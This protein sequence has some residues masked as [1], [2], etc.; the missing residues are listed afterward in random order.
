MSLW[1]TVRRVRVQVRGPLFA[2]DH[3]GATRKGDEPQVRAAFE[4]VV[5]Q[6]LGLDVDRA[7]GAVRLR[8]FAR[9]RAAVLG[10]APPLPPRPE[11]TRDWAL[12]AFA[13]GFEE[14][15]LARAVDAMFRGQAPARFA[16][17]RLARGLVD[18]RLVL[19]GRDVRA[20]RGW[21]EVGVHVVA[22]GEMLGKIADRHA[23]PF[24]ALALS[25]GLDDP[26]L[27]QVGAALELPRPPPARPRRAVEVRAD[28]LVARDRPG[29][30][31]VAT[32]AAGLRFVS[33]AED[34]GWARLDLGGGWAWAPLDALAPVRGAQAVEVAAAQPVVRVER[35]GAPRYASRGQ[36][37]VVRAA[38]ATLSEVQFDEAPA[39]I[40]ASLLRPV[41][42]EE[43]P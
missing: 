21:H 32:L 15:S 33:D 35:P 34:L 29:G 28:G 39:S 14:A 12:R 16:D 37:Y 24:P 8:D 3:D 31:G 40:R 23:L 25:N 17:G 7:S 42:L 9:L 4:A 10:A 36:A 38:G 43:P 13:D 22:A 27:I 41:A 30:L 1:A 6:R 26:N 5:G 18:E 2:I 20:W 11:T 19:G